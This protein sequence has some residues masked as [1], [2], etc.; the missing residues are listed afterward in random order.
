MSSR[1]PSLVISGGIGSGK[2]RLR[3]LLAASGFHTIDAD[4]IGHAILEPDGDAFSTVRAQ[5]PEVVVDGRIDRKALGRFVFGDEA[6]LVTLESITH[7]L[8]F[9]KILADLGDFEGPRAVEIPLLNHDLGEG[10]TRVIVD[11]PDQLR[12]E[13]VI[14]RGLSEPEAKARMAAQPG[15]QQWLAVADVVVPNT[16]SLAELEVGVR[17]VLE[18]WQAN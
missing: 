6:E 5:W 12:L 7:P 1:Q 2:S 9:G 3:E 18:A 8:I 10:W 13:R 17:R 16:G 11:A 4:A 14:A 15:R